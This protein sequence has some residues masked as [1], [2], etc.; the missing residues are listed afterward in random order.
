MDAISTSTEIE[1]VTPTA[2]DPKAKKPRAQRVSN[3]KLDEALRELN[4]LSISSSKLRGLGV[5]GRFLDQIGI[6]EYGNGR[7][8]GTAAAMEVALASCAEVVANAGDDNALK[9]RF[10]DLQLRI[11]KAIDAN[12]AMISRSQGDQP[13]KKPPSEHQIK[14]FAVGSIVVPVQINTVSP[15]EKTV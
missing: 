1:V 2:L 11:A 5:I 7:M 12:V 9:E 3:H 10:I 8:V 15:S 4:I 14:A 6:V 13:G